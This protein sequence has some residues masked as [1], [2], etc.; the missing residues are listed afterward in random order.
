MKA[1]IAPPSVGVPQASPPNGLYTNNIIIATTAKIGIAGG[2]EANRSR[3]VK[4]ETGG[5]KFLKLKAK[6]TIKS[7]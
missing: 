6:Q 3:Q 1:P 2:K 5:P 4:P 7:P